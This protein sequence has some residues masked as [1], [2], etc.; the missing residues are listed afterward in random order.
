MNLIFAVVVAAILARMVV[1]FVLVKI[2]LSY[3][4]A[5]KN[6]LPENLKGIVTPEAHARSAEYTS[7]HCHLDALR[8]LYG[9]AVKIGVISC[10][11]IPFVY[12]RTLALS[13]LDN[14]WAMSALIYLFGYAIGVLFWPFEWIGTFGIE[15]KYGFNRETIGLWIADEIKG[16]FLGAILSVP[17]IAVILWMSSGAIPYWWLWAF[18][19]VMT[20]EILLTII[21]PNVIEPLFNKFEPLKD[22][23]LKA[24]LEAMALKAHIN[25]KK[26][27][28]MDASK[29]SAHANA[30]FAGLGVSRR[31]VLYDTLLKQLDDAEIEAVLAHEIGHMKH[32]HILKGM[33]LSAMTQLVGFCLINLIINW[34][35]FYQSFGLAIQGGHAGGFLLL[36]LVSGAFTFWLTPLISRWYRGH[37]YQ[38][39][40]HAKDLV[41]SPQ[42][43]VSGLKKMTKESL[44][45]IE[46]HPITHSFYAS[47]PTLKEREDRLMIP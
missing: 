37:E 27:L 28:V 32:H 5:Q 38:A 7:E 3:A 1:Q 25:V 31:I 18:I 10:G 16:F 6:N 2:N 8:I 33:I 23:P 40:Q 12:N 21:Y 13:G 34:S 35:A 30:Y 22:G 24:R 19:V 9:G 15:Q 14:I 46:D 17:L 20:Y 36:S 26:I 41:G 45:S 43:L 44:A 42:P 29:R 11:I 4:A 47:H 39:D